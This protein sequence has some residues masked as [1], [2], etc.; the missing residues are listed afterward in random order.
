VRFVLFND[1][2]IPFVK[3]AK[4]HDDHFHVALLG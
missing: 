4:R 3:M 1:T 2:G